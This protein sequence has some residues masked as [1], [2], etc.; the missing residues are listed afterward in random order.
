[1]ERK[2][3]QDAIVDWIA[4]IAIDWENP[5]IMFYI[6]P[7]FE[8]TRAIMPGKNLKIREPP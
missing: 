5:R 6:G 8:Q 7:L 2:F 1:M 4:I 3:P